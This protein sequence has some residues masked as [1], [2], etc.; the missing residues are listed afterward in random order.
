MNSIREDL[1]PCLGSAQQMS[2]KVAQRHCGPGKSFISSQ[3]M[4]FQW[5]WGTQGHYEGPSPDGVQLEIVP[6]VCLVPHWSALDSDDLNYRP[7][8]RTQDL[9][10]PASHSSSF[11]FMSGGKES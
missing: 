7:G 2:R 3:I 1:F 5:L 4:R 6:F 11:S 9:D 8:E 10:R